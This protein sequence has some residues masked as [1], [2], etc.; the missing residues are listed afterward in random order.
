MNAHETRAARRALGLSQSSLVVLVWLGLSLVCLALAGAGRPPVLNPAARAGS[1]SVAALVQVRGETARL[2]GTLGPDRPAAVRVAGNRLVNTAGRPVRLIGVDRSG[3]EY[4]CAQGWGIFD[5]PSSAASVAAM[6]AWG[7]NAIR[8]PLNEDCWLGINGVAPARGGIAYRRA[9]ATYVTLLRRAGM[10]AVV[11]LHWSAPG[12]ELAAGQQ[13]MADASHSVAFW[14]SVASALRGDRNVVFDLYNEPHDI[15]W[16]CWLAG[17]TLP[18]TA[19]HPAWRAAGMQQLVDAVRTTGAAQ[20]IMVGGLAWA[21]DLTGWL[22]H[23]PVDPRHQLIASVHIYNYSGC[24][25]AACWNR[26]IGRVAASVPVVTGELGQNTCTGTFPDQYMAWADVHHV[27]YLAWTWNT[28]GCPSGLIR[29][30][31]GAPSGW[32][33]AYRAHLRRLSP[34]RPV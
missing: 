1:G 13:D 19:G 5:G 34:A 4:A 28:W 18:A 17:C 6:A 21:G 2:A 22:A 32:G 12:A 11:D 8:I 30:Y 33:T 10:V 16:T 24:R 27:S 15:S 14:H 26:T 29:S 9:I 7:I 25:T 31:A 23:K 20:P 3:T